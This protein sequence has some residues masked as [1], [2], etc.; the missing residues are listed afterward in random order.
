MPLPNIASFMLTLGC[1]HNHQQNGTYGCQLPGAEQAAPVL[2]CS[3]HLSRPLAV[4]HHAAVKASILILRGH[5]VPSNNPTTSQ[6]AMLLQAT[7]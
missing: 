6:P 1:C 7:R 2:L 4:L 5:C 3:T